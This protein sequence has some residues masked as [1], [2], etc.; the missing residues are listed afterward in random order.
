MAGPARLVSVMIVPL[1]AAIA[2]GVAHYQTG[3]EAMWALICKTDDAATRYAY[4]AS[5]SYS[6][7]SLILQI[8]PATLILPFVVSARR[9]TGRG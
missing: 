4:I 9:Q 7:V 3:V 5:N 2:W 6:A 1:A 8:L